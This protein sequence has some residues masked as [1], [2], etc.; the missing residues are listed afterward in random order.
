MSTPESKHVVPERQPLASASPEVGHDRPPA[1]RRLRA[2]WRILIALIASIVVVVL[3]DMGLAFVGLADTVT[4][5]GD[6]VRTAGRLLAVFGVVALTARWLDRRRL[7]DYGLRGGRSWWADVAFGAAVGFGMFALSAGIGI[8]AGWIEVRDTLSPASTGGVWLV[9]ALAM[10]R[11]AAVSLWEEVLFR[12]VM[13]R[14]AAESFGR[15]W[16][17][18]RA[19]LVATVI[20][21]VVFALVHVPQSLGAEGMSLV[22]MAILWVT[23]GGL[24]AVPY[25]VTGQLAL[26]LGLHLTINLAVQN[27]FVMWEQQAEQGAV[28]LHLDA[29][30]A[31]VLAGVGGVLQVGAIALGYLV[32]LG[33]LRW[34]YGSLRIHPSLTEIPAAAQTPPDGPDRATTDEASASGDTTAVVSTGCTSRTGSRSWEGTEEP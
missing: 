24:L 4:A 1:D 14:N 10:L 17:R 33:W 34:R 25:L 21:T 15:R 18:T 9:L 6:L 3:T 13:I 29:S 12:G 27:V 2:R 28:V 11:F 20:S 5:T 30:G 31:D 23:L 16:P 32:V 22:R 26:S 19:V 8:A 7:R